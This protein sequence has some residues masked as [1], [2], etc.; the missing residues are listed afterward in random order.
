MAIIHIDLRS[1]RPI[2]EQLVENI[3][4]LVLLG[5]IAPDEQLPSVRALASE[6]GINPNT[7]Q[8]AYGILEERGI[9]YS[10]AGRGNFASPDVSRV[11]SNARQ[12]LLEEIRRSVLEARRLGASKEEISAVIESV[13]GEKH[14]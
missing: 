13:W 12:S 5:L 4:H 2:S 3:T 7:I 11:K 14:D 9:I 8:K 10:Q 6:L 1:R